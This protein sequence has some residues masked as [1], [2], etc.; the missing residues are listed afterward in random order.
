M[1]A[2]GKIKPNSQINAEKAY[3]ILLD[4]VIKKKMTLSI[5]KIKSFFSKTPAKMQ[6]ITQVATDDITNYDM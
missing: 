3:D 5:P 6:D 2:K 4:T 1:D